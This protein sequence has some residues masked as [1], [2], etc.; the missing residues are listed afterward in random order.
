MG[1]EKSTEMIGTHTIALAIE[2]RGFLDLEFR[3]LWSHSLGRSV[4]V[5]QCPVSAVMLGVQSVL[6]F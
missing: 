5:L 2:E 3:W 4:L 1:Q 6:T